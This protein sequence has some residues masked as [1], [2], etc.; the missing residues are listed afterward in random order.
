MFHELTQTSASPWLFGLHKAAPQ[1][2]LYPRKS[3]R[4]GCSAQDVTGM[5]GLV[6]GL[7]PNKNTQSQY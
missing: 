4:T 3:T 5:V 2:S 6:R 7:N 1:P